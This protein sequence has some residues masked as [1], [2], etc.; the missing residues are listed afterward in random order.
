M[1]ACMMSTIGTTIASF[2]NL[3][4]VTL[5]FLVDLTWNDPLLYTQ[6][7]IA[8]YTLPNGGYIKLYSSNSDT[9]DT[10]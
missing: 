7:H 3:Q 2:I 8:D 9:Q 10:C 1:G 4:E 6:I 5:Q